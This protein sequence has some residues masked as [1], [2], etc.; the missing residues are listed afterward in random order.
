MT[1]V[2]YSIVKTGSPIPSGPLWMYLAIASGAFLVALAATVLPT[3][4]ATRVR[5]IAALTT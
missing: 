2:P 5:P 4:R 3:L 1:A